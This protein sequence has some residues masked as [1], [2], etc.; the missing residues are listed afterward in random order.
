M[1]RK[2]RGLTSKRNDNQRRKIQLI[3]APSGTTARF[4]HEHDGNTHF[5]ERPVI[6][7]DDDGNALIHDGRRSRDLIPARC[8]GNYAGLSAE[9]SGVCYTGL[10]P[11]GS[12]RIEFTGGDGSKWS[13]PL[14][15]WALQSDGSIVPL[16]AYADGLVDSLDHYE[17]EYRVY[18]PDSEE[19][20]PS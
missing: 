15:G 18:H 12:W 8:L 6:A 4:K 20:G 10:I 3:P 13:E 17:G 2:K 11:A 1:L 14:V 7:F 16:C 9:P 5:S 19:T